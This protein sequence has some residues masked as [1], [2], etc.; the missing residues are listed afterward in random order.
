MESTSIS[1]AENLAD[2]PQALNRIDDF[3]HRL[4]DIDLQPEIGRDHVGQSTG[5]LEVFDHDHDVGN[6][7]FAETHDLFDLLLDGPHDGFCLKGGSRRL[8][9]GQ[10]VDPDG[11]I[12]IGLNVF[13]RSSLW[14]V[15]AP[16]F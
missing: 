3:Q 11:V 13:L 4:R 14:R 12:G 10:L 7:D 9:F 5:I 8:V 2:L 6:Q 1:F 15:P 16:G